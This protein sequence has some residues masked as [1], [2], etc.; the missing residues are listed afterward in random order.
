MCVKAGGL[1]SSIC[2][3]GLEAWGAHEVCRGLR[4]GELHMCV[5]A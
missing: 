4:L 1:G 3:L 5:R 2:V